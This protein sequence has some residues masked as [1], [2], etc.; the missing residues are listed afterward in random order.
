[1]AA[2]NA[3]TEV[4]ADRYGF[5]N[6]SRW[7]GDLSVGYER[8]RETD[9]AKLRGPTL[10]WEVPIFNQRRDSLLRAN[11][12]FI[13]AINEVDRLTTEVQ[14]QVRLAHAATE[15]AK[16]RAN[17]YRE[18]LIP[19]RIEAVERAQEEENFMIIG[20]FEL[21]QTKQQEYDAYQGYLEVVRDY[22]LSRAELARAVGTTLPSSTQIGDEY[23][24]VDKYVQPKS[25]DPHAGHNTMSSQ[26]NQQKSKDD[27]TAP[28]NEPDAH[29]AH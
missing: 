13:I 10:D 25:S 1:L 12:N 14:N 16:S 22:W 11:A 2:A 27:M 29:S 19:A 15:N 7:I 26:P 8:E 23:L 5:T 3:R 18:Q 24:S 20:I 6:W 17:E 4:L 9:G 28:N 21:L